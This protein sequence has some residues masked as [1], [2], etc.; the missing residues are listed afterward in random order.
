MS[1]CLVHGCY[2]EN[3]EHRSG[4]YCKDHPCKESDYFGYAPPSSYC[5]E[6]GAKASNDSSS[7]ASEDITCHDSDC[8][9]DQMSDSDYCHTHKCRWGEIDCMP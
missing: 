9:D 4:N 1:Q 6:H 7:E 5:K 2:K 8:D 3:K